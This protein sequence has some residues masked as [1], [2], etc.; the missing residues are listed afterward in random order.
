MPSYQ[1]IG[2]FDDGIMLL[3]CLIWH[4]QGNFSGVEPI[5]LTG[6]MDSMFGIAIV[7]MGDI[8]LDG[9]EGKI[10]DRQA[11]HI[12]GFRLGYSLCGTMWLGS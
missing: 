5:R 2:S 12:G 3:I 7:N 6:P 1:C 4:F 10:Y 8:N 9:Y 11:W